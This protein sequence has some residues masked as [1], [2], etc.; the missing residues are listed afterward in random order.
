MESLISSLNSSK[1]VDSMINI[2]VK[3][4]NIDIVDEYLTSVNMSES[5]KSKEF[6]SSWALSRFPDEIMTVKCTDLCDASTKLCEN[7]NNKTELENLV[8]NYKTLFNNWKTED[9]K[10]LQSRP[11]ISR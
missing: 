10:L 11:E 6:L 1:T 8:S 4:E 7:W 9:L 5:I 2:L 3:K